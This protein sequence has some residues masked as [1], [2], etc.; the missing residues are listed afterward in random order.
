MAIR[1]YPR[2]LVLDGEG[3][4]C[5]GHAGEDVQILPVGWHNVPSAERAARCAPAAKTLIHAAQETVGASVAQ[6]P[7]FGLTFP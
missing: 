4:L 1:R 6:I 7:L 2:W 5:P 3:R